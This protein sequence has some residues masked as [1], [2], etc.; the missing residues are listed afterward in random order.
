MECTQQPRE[1]V[2]EPAVPR[3]PRQGDREHE[4]RARGF[5]GPAAAGRAAG[6]ACFAT[7]RLTCASSVA[8]THTRGASAGA[9]LPRAAKAHLTCP[10]AR[11]IHAR[12]VL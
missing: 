12:A 1:T 8:R 5:T 9:A 11:A 3:T 10:V 6:R 4:Q 7:R 2:K